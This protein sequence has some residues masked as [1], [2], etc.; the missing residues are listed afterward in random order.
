MKL[1]HA[2]SARPSGPT[3]GAVAATYKE[4]IPGAPCSIVAA[5]AI[6]KH[7]AT[8]T[9]E[10]GKHNAHNRDTHTSLVGH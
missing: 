7:T 10:S 6:L 5:L 9:G 2:I 1:T 8:C 3:L 4:V